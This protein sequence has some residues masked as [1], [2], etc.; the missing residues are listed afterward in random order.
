MGLGS[1]SES[2]NLITPRFSATNTLPSAANAIAVG[3]N[4]PE[5][6]TDVVEPGRADSGHLGGRSG[7]RARIV[8]QA[9]HLR[10]VGRSRRRIDCAEWPGRHEHR[11]Q[12]DRRRK[13][14]TGGGEVDGRRSVR[15]ALSHRQVFHGRRYKYQRI[16]RCRHKSRCDDAP[17][18]KPNMW[19]KCGVAPILLRPWLLRRLQPIRSLRSAPPFGPGS[20]RH[21]RRRR[22]PR[23]RAG[24]R[25]RP[26]ITR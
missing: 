3:L 12:N 4:R 8:R 18:A 24:R 14:R 21:S 17:A 15:R 13:S 7:R 11:P 25:S 22:R 1:E 26:G 2:K 23:R 19:S 20:R 9:E 10:P 5:K 6:T 16:S